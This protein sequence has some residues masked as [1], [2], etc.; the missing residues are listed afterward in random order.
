V[1][2]G[3]PSG[4]PVVLASA[5]PR[6][7]E[8]LQALV[9]AFEVREPQLD[10]VLGDDPVAD[11][12]RLALA[13]AAAVAAGHPHAVVLGADTVV[14][15]GR[16][17]YGEPTSAEEAV[18]VLRALRGREHT[19]VTGVAAVRDGQAWIG[20]SNVHVWLADLDDEAI[21]AY[22]ASGRPMDKAGAYA[23]Q[24]D[25]VPTVQRWQGCYCA[26]VGLP[27]WVACRALT[28]MG[29]HPDSPVAAYPR[30][31]AC[32]DRGDP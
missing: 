26:V 19:V 21:A 17:H 8:L 30:C 15:D 9:R 2:P 6:R 29:L 4:A 22:V 10:E 25:D 27:L 18:A 13:K 16:R 31:A 20:H 23:I 12:R 32:P 24:D 14:H 28:A 5:S 1:S 11:A 3:G 7:R